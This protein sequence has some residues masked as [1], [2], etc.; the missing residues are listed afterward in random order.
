MS[1][2]LCNVVLKWNKQNMQKK[3]KTDH[4]ILLN[5]DYLLQWP[6][7]VRYIHCGKR[8]YIDCALR[9]L[10]SNV[11]VKQVGLLLLSLIK[12][13]WLDKDCLF[14]TKP[15]LILGYFVTSPKQLDLKKQR[16]EMTLLVAPLDF[17]LHQLLLY[18]DVLFNFSLW[19][20]NYKCIN[21]YLVLK[22]LSDF[23]SFIFLSVWFD[24]SFYLFNRTALY[25][26]TSL[27]I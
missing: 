4:E 2:A 6:T 15:L 14:W 13:Y 11:V 25:F 9:W 8:D 1:L 22:L 23:I 3:K 18:F 20:H 26:H 24:F 10:D 5:Q 19:R 27:L 21:N 17:H 7:K 16:K 12:Q